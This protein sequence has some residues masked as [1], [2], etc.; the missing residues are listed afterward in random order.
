MVATTVKQSRRVVARRTQ[1]SGG[2]VS[3]ESAQ[4]GESGEIDESL[5]NDVANSGGDE[6]LQVVGRTRSG[7][8]AVGAGITW[9][10]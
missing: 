8:S 3:A 10:I 7:G 2:G 6:R 5:G 1:R 4:D 9:D